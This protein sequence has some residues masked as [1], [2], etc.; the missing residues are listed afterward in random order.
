M[1]NGIIGRMARRAF[2]RALRFAENEVPGLP[3]G[4]DGKERL[5]YLHVPF[6]EQLCPYCSFHRVPFDEAACRAYFAALRKEICL[7]RDGGFAFTG[8][9]VGG[10]TPTVLL[11]ELSETLRL[12]RSLFPIRGISLETNPN[13]LTESCVATLAALGVNRLSVGVQ[14]FH[15]G[16]LEAM[17]RR[18]R[19]GSGEETAR[20]LAAVQG[21][22]ETVNADMI[23]N[24]PGQTEDMLA[25]DLERLLGLAV[26]Q[27]TFYP[28]MV[29]S[30]T[31]EAVGRKLGP[32][33][34]RREEALYGRIARTLAPVYDFSSAWCF[35]RKGRLSM[36]DEYVVDHG[37]YAGLGSGAIGYVAGRCYANTFDLALY[38]ERLA[39]GVVPIMA[40]R[41][42]SEREQARYDFLM[43]LFGTSLDV[44]ALNRKYRGRLYRHIWRDMLAFQL[45]GS[46]RY[47]APRL[48]LTERGRYHWVILMREFFTAVNNFRAYCRSRVSG[49]GPSGDPAAR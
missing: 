21:R 17:E 18:A 49:A 33:D 30:A 7:Y 34:F 47:W 20:R 2:S 32:V 44:G 37:E 39:R 23:F 46:I 16:L 5:L 4:G 27:V 36:I 38:K 6:C 29:S 14:S 8:V 22:F 3:A 48:V 24:F 43:Q 45:A 40:A 10:G 11:D 28:L 19:Y 41:Q 31:R 12:A 13:H 42:F 9:Y 1:I 25:A 15:D 26:D 35:S